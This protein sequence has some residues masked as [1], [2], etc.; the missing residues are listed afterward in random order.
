MSQ[1]LQVLEIVGLV[2]FALSSV[3]VGIEYELDI[4]GIFF[5][6][7]CTS[8]AGGVVRDVVLGVEP[9]FMF[10]HYE[11][12]LTVVVTVAV[13]LIVFKILDKKLKKPAIRIIKRVVDVFDA[14]GLGVFTVSGCQTA[15]NMGLGDNFI[16]MVFVGMI[17]AVG[18]GIIRDL[19]AGRKP[20]VVRKEIY[21]LASI[22]GTIVYY[23][24]HDKMDVSAAMYL[25]AA[26]VT[27]VRVIAS[28]RRITLSYAL[29]N[30]DM[31][32]DE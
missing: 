23:F 5:I 14:I 4:F 6:A 30:D 1:G 20:V 22:G 9:P 11:Y 29:R 15:V 31:K 16:L 21:A 8:L 7:L 25:T 13:S 19:L 3:F 32:V 2:A 28:L 27:I 26:L 12:V 18:G 10:L 24:I 17:T